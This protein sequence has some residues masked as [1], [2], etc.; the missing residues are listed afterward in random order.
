M[1]VTVKPGDDIRWVG[2][3]TQEGVADFVGCVLTSEIRSRSE[4][5]GSMTSLQAS[6]QIEWL[7]TVEGTFSYSI[8]RS[9]TA[10]WPKGATLYLDVRVTS[11]DGTQIR[12]ATAQFKTEPGVTA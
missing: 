7:D 11:S 10:N 5:D 6:V 8:D 12:T 4:I 1:I 3:L 9:V 2:Q